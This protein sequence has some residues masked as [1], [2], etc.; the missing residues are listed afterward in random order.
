MYKVPL[1]KIKDVRP[2][3][4]ADR[5]DIVKCY[6]FELVTK[7]DSFKVG[8]D[9]IFVP[10]DSVLPTDLEKYLFPEES[11]IKL[12]NGRIKQIRIRS[13]PSSGML[14]SKQEVEQ[15]LNQRGDLV[16]LRAY[17]EKTKSLDW[18]DEKDYSEILQ[19]KKY[20]PP[21]PEYHAANLAKGKKGRQAPEHPQFHCY[22]GLENIKWYPELFTPKIITNS[23]SPSLLSPTFE[24]VVVTEK[25]HGSSIKFGYLPTISFG[26]WDKIKSWLGLLPKFTYRYGSNNVDITRKANY[27]GF[28]GED[29]YGQVVKKYNAFSKLKPNEIVYGEVYGEGI[30]GGYSY[31]IK[32]HKLVI[33]D[34]KVFQEDNTTWRWLSPEEVEAF[35]KERGFDHVPVLYKGS[36]VK[37]DV[38]KLLYGPSLLGKQSVREGIVIKSRYKYQDDFMPSSKRALKWISPDFLDTNST[39][40][41]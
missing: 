34:V 20:D 5:L 33:F 10:I 1:T 40:Y 3:P 9:T 41:H 38:Q 22:R 19:I 21:A 36:F 11:K 23:Q 13:F 24:E 15:F 14:I 27:K 37:E 39:D 31:G 30:Q 35:A 4:N 26:F 12:V 18:E 32:E 29:V 16:H 28:Y 25:I 2:H 8:D 7:K 17:N 6:D